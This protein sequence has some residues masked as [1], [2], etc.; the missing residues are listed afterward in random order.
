MGTFTN[1][2]NTARAQRQAP[3]MHLLCR[4]FINTVLYVSG[5]NSGSPPGA[6]LYIRLKKLLRYI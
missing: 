1:Q 4:T 3:Y 6:F 5:V 2:N